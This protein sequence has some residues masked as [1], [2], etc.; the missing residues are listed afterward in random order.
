[1]I[2]SIESLCAFLNLV[3]CKVYYVKVKI[4]I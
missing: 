4:F 3:F 2:L 1:M